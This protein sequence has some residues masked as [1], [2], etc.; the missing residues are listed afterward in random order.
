MDGLPVR[1]EQNPGVHRE[2]RDTL[3]SDRLMQSPR[4]ALVYPMAQR[5]ASQLAQRYGSSAYPVLLL[6]AVARYQPQVPTLLSLIRPLIDQ[7]S[8][9]L[10]VTV[11]RPFLVQ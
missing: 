9:L 4:A 11:V 3:D 1:L 5:C 2:C 6:N 10:E 7:R 8:Y